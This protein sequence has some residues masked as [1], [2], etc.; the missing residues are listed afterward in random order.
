MRQRQNVEVAQFLVTPHIISRDLTP[1]LVDD[2][3]L[4]QHFQIRIDHLP[5]KS[6]L[7]NVPPPYSV[8]LGNQ[9]LLG[10]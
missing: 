5:S 3:D 2:S 6:I 9:K 8:L 7:A 1:S 10:T 4:L